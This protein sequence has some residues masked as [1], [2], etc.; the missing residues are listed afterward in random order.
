MQLGHIGV[1]GVPGALAV[2]SDLNI[3]GSPRLD[4]CIHAPGKVADIAFVKKLDPALEPTKDQMEP[5]QVIVHFI[6]SDYSHIEQYL[7]GI[8]RASWLESM[9]DLHEMCLG[10]QTDEWLQHWM[11]GKESGHE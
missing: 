1:G 8:K 6:R 2:Y 10:K 4:I 9:L 5:A 11:R 3:T 7:P